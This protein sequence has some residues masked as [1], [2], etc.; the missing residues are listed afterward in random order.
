MG[1]YQVVVRGFCN[2][3]MAGLG[4]DIGEQ[5]LRNDMFFVVVFT[6]WKLKFII[7]C[8]D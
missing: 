1:Y 2:G 4:P 7:S 3:Q 5:L 6:S 8:V